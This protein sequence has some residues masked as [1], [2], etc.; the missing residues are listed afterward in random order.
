MVY[1]L[2]NVCSAGALAVPITR[3]TLCQSTFH[4]RDAIIYNSVDYEKGTLNGK[5][6][7]LKQLIGL[8][9]GSAV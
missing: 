4:D 3:G 8:L 9:L 2:G 6:L 5:L 1:S 7:A